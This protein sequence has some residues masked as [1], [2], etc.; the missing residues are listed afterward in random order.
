VL[1]GINVEKLINK[2]KD[3]SVVI[4]IMGLGYVG[5][6][7][8]MAFAKKFNVIGYDVSEKTV[9]TLKSGKS[10]IKD[11]LPDVLNTYLGSSFHPTSNAD[12]LS[13]CDFFIICVPTPLNSELEPELK[14]VESATTT[15]SKILRQDQFV[16]LESTTYPGTTDEVIVPILEDSG[17]KAGVDFGVAHSPERIDPGNTSKVEDIPKVIGGINDKCTEI[18]V[19]VYGSV[20]KHIVP[21]TNARTAEAVKILENTFRCVNIA[22]INEMSL[23][24]DIMGIDT[25]EIVQAATTKPYGF[26]SFYPGPGIGGHCIPL[27]PYYLSYQAKMLGFMPRFIEVAGEVNHYMKIYTLN[28][29]RKALSCVGKQIRNANVVVFGLAYKKNINDARESP[30]SYIIESLKKLGANV[31]VYDPYVSAFNTQ[32]GTLYNQSSIEEAL[33]DADCAIFL[34]DHDEYKDIDQKTMTTLMKYPIIIDC[35]NI[36]NKHDNIMYYGIGKGSSQGSYKVT[37]TASNTSS[38]NI[39]TKTIKVL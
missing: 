8:A 23:I 10:H 26:M 7:L 34:V 15:I 14:Y 2:I 5:F 28:L 3:N 21:V 13:K 4:G 20:L 29:A 25:W 19:M 32:F 36:F 16:V 33:K 35:K 1:W 6:P 31:T 22:L 12:D 11:V 30:A 38:S 39:I 9:T 37:S 24:F 27:D 18:A 17:L